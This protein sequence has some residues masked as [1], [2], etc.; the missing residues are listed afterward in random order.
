MDL[1]KRQDAIDAVMKTYNYESDRMTAL[2]EIPTVDA[3][4]VVH[5]HWDYKNYTWHCSVCDCHPYKGYIPAKAD[6]KY[7]PKCGA[8]MVT[9]DYAQKHYEAV[10]KRMKETGLTNEEMAGD[11]FGKGGK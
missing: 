10:K 2:Q 5:G 7:C 1:I 9:D 3:V 4:P 8:K 11:F 6:Y